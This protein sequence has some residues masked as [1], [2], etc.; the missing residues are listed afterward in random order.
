VTHA[1]HQAE[2]LAKHQVQPMSI[3]AGDQATDAAS[4]PLVRAA[5]NRLRAP[6]L[7]SAAGAHHDVPPAAGSDVSVNRRTREARCPPQA[8]RAR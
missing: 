7:K 1:K 6:R 5:H 2:S 8:E 3:D 4:P